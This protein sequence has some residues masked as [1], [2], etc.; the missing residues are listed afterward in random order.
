[1]AVFDAVV[2]GAGPAGCLCAEELSRAGV[3]VALV[4]R[5]GVGGVCLNRGCIPS[6]AVLG[7]AEIIGRLRAL[8]RFDFPQLGSFDG[9]SV[10][11]L[12]NHAVSLSARALKGTLKERGVE[13]IAGEVVGAGGGGVEVR[14]DA[15]SLELSCDDLIV[16]IGSKSASIAE[17]EFDGRRVVDP[18]RFLM[19]EGLPKSLAVIGAGNIGV[20]LAQ[21]A[22]SWGAKVSLI[23]MMPRI[24]PDVPEDTAKLVKDELA[25]GG[26]KVHLESEVVGVEPRGGDVRLRFLEGGAERELEAEQLLVAV[27]RKPATDQG[28]LGGLG[29][30]FGQGGFIEVDSCGQTSVQGVFA[31]GD[32]TSGPMLAHRAY[33]DAVRASARIAHGEVLQVPKAIPRVIF[34]RPEIAVVGMGE[35]EAR[36]SG[37]DVLVKTY[38]FAGLGRANATGERTGFV[39][40]VVDSRTGEVVG[41][42]IVGAHASELAGIASVLVEWRITVDQLAR[43]VFAHPTLSEIFW[44]AARS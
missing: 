25:R 37:V 38:P 17:A 14:A 33:A 36:S 28:W 11:A 16:A 12:R 23:E 21:A 20:E 43:T 13:L 35:S 9:R 15:G 24:L 1:M 31:I 2:I 26:V 42:E 39:R 6:K 4:E 3:K 29:L 30:A 7:A 40:L 44:K 41:V 34:S 5:G 10:V 22:C 32:C 18:E 8:K 27:G 19:Q